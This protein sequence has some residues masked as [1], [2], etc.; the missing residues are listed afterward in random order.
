MEKILNTAR[1]ILYRFLEENMIHKK[2]TYCSDFNIH[3][4]IVGFS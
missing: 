4:D 2:H 3:I 1:S